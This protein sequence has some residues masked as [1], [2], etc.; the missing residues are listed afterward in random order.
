[1]GK[2]TKAEAQKRRR[3][4]WT[5]E[6]REAN[7]QRQAAWR[8]E[9]PDYGKTWYR[10][11]RERQLANTRKW[12]RIYS[13]VA[14]AHGELP[15]GPCEICAKHCKK[16]VFDHDHETGKF[17]GWLCHRCNVGLRYVEESTYMQA[18]LA[19]LARTIGRS[20]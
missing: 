19:Y 10:A 7:R 9:N 14:D 4:A 1:M 15:S 2:E 8:A 5:P 13:G 17:R 6:Q 12:Q 16:L 3:A 18:A 11:N 20:A